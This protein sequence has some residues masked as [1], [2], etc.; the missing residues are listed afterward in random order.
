MATPEACV[1]ADSL[2]AKEAKG[3]HPATH[4][5]GDAAMRDTEYLIR[6]TNCGEIAY[7]DVVFTAK[8]AAAVM[9]TLKHVNGWRFTVGL[10]PKPQS[11]GAS[12]QAGSALGPC[13]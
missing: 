6:I 2:L 8:I 3:S 4:D 1:S 10:V 11:A 13:D 9:P 12:R 5:P 7:G